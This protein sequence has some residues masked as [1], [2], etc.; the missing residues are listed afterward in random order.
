M[1]ENILC[2]ITLPFTSKYASVSFNAFSPPFSPDFAEPQ[3]PWPSGPTGDGREP[4]DDS[5]LSYNQRN[6]KKWEKDEPLGPLA[7]SSPVLYANLEH[8]NLKTDYPGKGN[9]R[10]EA[11]WEFRKL[12]L[13]EIVVLKGTE[14]HFVHKILTKLL[15]FPSPDCSQNE[16]KNKKTLI[17]FIHQS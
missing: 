8:P 14:C 15:L 6:V 2:T 1:P 11:F 5:H 9:I 13:P 10:W 16:N 12:I 4:G 7:T 17:V 3:S